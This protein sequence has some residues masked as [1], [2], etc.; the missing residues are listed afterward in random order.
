MNALLWSLS[1][2][3]LTAGPA[4]AADAAPLSAWLTP[5]PATAPAVAEVSE[6]GAKTP[7]TENH[8]EVTYYLCYGSPPISCTGHECSSGLGWV[9][10]DGDRTYCPPCTVSCWQPGFEC[11]S[12]LGDCQIYGSP[13]DPYKVR[14]DSTFVGCP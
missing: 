9:E 7:P 3:L 12:Y 5:P 1:L 11:T 6:D 10:C 8:C 14:C 2:V 13:S 4:P